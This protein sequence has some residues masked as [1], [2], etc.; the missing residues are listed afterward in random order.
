MV[1]PLANAIN[2]LQ[3]FGFYDVVL[4]FLLIFTIIFAVLEKTKIFGTEE[5]GGKQIPR[6]NINSMVA[7]VIALF[8]VA[9]TKIVKAIQ[10]SLPQVA[11][12]L[13]IIISFLLLAGSLIGGEEKSFK[14]GGTW[15]VLI[16]IILFVA[17]VAVFFNA[18]GWLNPV[19]DYIKEHWEDTFIV[20]VIF[21][22]IMI[23]TIIYIVREKKE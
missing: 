7:F 3:E 21:F 5:V 23:G 10:I 13:V 19:L 9:A 17:I 6:K 16:T 20:S 15:V 4:P 12:I 2:F 8:F 18:F 11:L 1:S 22:A 14:L